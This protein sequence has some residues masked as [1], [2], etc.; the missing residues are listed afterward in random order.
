MRYIVSPEERDV[1]ITVG[2]DDEMAV[3]VNGREAFRGRH[4]KGLESET[5]TAHFVKGRNRILVKLSNYANT[6]WRAWAFT[7]AV[8]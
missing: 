8:K 4:D 3:R 1:Q 6:T 7:F 2:F 5:F